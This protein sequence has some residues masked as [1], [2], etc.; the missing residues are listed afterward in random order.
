MADSKITALTALTAADPANDMIPIVDVSDT[1]PASGNTKRISINNILACS[2]S[3]TLASATITGALTAGTTTL[4]A[5]AAGYTGKVGINTATPAATLDIQGTTNRLQVQSSSNGA[6]ATWKYIGKNSS[7][8]AVNFEQ[9]LNIAADNA[10]ELYDNQNTQLVSRYISG[11]SGYH[12]WFLGGITGLTLNSTGNLVLKGGTAGATGVGLTF[13]ATQV[14]SSDA[15]CLDDYEEGTWT[16]T[17]KGSTTDP[18]TPVTATGRYTKI[19]RSVTVDIVFSGV[20]TTGAVG[21]IS[22]T[23]LPFANGSVAAVGSAGI[24]AILAYSGTL[25]SVVDPSGTTIFLVS[26]ISSSYASLATHVAGASKNLLISITYS[27]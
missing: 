6:Y 9:G 3:A 15:N 5:N 23:G 21:D 17:I 12:S 16:G 10:F 8:T 22:V 24:G 7:G 20:T 26:Q 18:T 13:P 4:V 19:G 2:P 1:P 11:V 27:V 14:A 25:T